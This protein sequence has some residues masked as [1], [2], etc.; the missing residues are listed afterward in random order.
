MS[1]WPSNYEGPTRWEQ[2]GPK[3]LRDPKNRRPAC[4]KCGH[5]VL[6]KDIGL[7]DA[8]CPVPGC[9]CEGAPPFSQIVLTTSKQVFAVADEWRRT[10]RIRRPARRTRRKRNTSR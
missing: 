10:G 7:H 4:K 2:F 6:H 1:L 9:M 8:C 3:Y 5:K